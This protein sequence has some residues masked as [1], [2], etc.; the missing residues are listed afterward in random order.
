MRQKCCISYVTWPGV[1]LI[2][3]YSWAKPAILAASKGRG[4]MFL[5]RLFLHCHSFLACGDYVPGELMLSPSLWRRRP[6]PRPCR[7]PSP[8]PR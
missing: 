2:L 6:H 5:S 7:R 8:C 1:Q 3:T 4:G